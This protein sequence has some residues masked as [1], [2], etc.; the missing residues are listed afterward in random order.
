M[1]FTL[2][3]PRSL[4]YKINEEPNYM[5]FLKYRKQNDSDKK[6]EGKEEI[7]NNYIKGNRF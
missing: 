4:L 5:Y 2:Y 6:N 3:L 1:V 7:I